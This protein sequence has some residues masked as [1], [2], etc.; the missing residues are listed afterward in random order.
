MLMLNTQPEQGARPMNN[1]TEFRIL[2]CALAGMT[3][4]GLMVLL[5][6]SY[7]LSATVK[8]FAFCAPML[9]VGMIAIS[10][11]WTGMVLGCL[12]LTFS[13]PIA[14]L[15]RLE[16]GMIVIGL[17]CALAVA[18]LSV[19]RDRHGV[20]FGIDAYAM[21][22]VAIMVCARF[23][24]D[25]P[26][27]ARMGG[28][29]GGGEAVVFVMAVLAYFGV[30]IVTTSNWPT[31]EN[32]RATVVIVAVCAIAFTVMRIAGNGVRGFTVLFSRQY[33]FLFALLL[34]WSFHAVVRDKQSSWT[35]RALPYCTIGLLL[36]S[37]IVSP[38]RSRPLFA[39]GIVLAV[40]WVYSR[41]PRAA[42]VFT[43]CGALVIGLIMVTRSGTLPAP[44]MRTLSTIIPTEPAEIR[45]HK[46]EADVSSEVGWKSGFRAELYRIAWRHVRQHPFLGKGFAFSRDEII[47]AIGLQHAHARFRSLSLSGGY[48][49]SIVQLAVA[50]G[51]PCALLFLL[52]YAIG[53]GKFARDVRRM[54]D[55]HLL[56]LSAGMI[57]LFVAQSGQMLMNGGS[58]DF[59]VICVLL[60]AM[61]GIRVREGKARRRNEVLDN[62]S[63]P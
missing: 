31:R 39:I 48:H 38:H 56:I 26:G 24:Y 32:L 47:A 62:H 41:V 14:V 29:G 54:K 8:A 10:R 50:C 4:M 58:H 30:A 21:L 57:G 59:F 2:A 61:K 51:V 34:A 17:V 44:M 43:A 3:L 37:S 63:E 7:D 55:P 45:W 22:I 28:T 46:G 20:V 16:G 12:A 13:L 5:R 40:S 23:L 35:L 1:K 15:Y 36:I 42:L 52:A 53:I 25:R 19:R 9:L 11:I 18:A 49:N 6:G 60:G 27:S 33:W